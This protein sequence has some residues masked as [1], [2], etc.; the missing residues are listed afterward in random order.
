MNARLPLLLTILALGLAAGCGPK[1]G[2]GGPPPGY[3]S[4]VKAVTVEVRPVEEK[5]SLVASITANESI[6]VK[7][8]LDGI[9]EKV[10]FEEGQPVEE[11]QVLIKLDTRKWEASVAE[12]E[13]DFKL[14]ESNRARAESM[15]KNQ[16]IALQ[17]FDQAV[18]TFEARKASLDLMKQQL[19][20]ARILARFSG[21][22]GA[23]LVSPGQVI[24]KTTLLTTLID[25]EP[26]KVE[27]RVPERFL[28]QLRI[29]QTIAFRVPAYPGEEFRGQVYFIDPQVDVATRTVLVKAT[30][31]NLDRRLRPGMFGNLD[32]ILT[33]REQALVVPESA[34]LRDGESVTLYIIS[35]EGTAQMVPVELGARLPGFVEIVKGLSGG[36][37]VIYEGTQKI[38]PGAPVHNTLD[39][40]A[41]PATEPQAEATPE[42]APAP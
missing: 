8:E 12:A 17:E 10:N 37:K 3:A 15:L 2:G 14:A 27:F 40:Q 11:G 35:P 39:E 41:P 18:A 16:T 42:T 7:S 9:I 1:Q 31:P 33:V 13:A 19:K 38:G 20:D 4:N 21:L 24:S 26:V 30:Q 32:L 6:E 29:G 23:R 28:G 22:A 36:E 34:I 5:I 25:L